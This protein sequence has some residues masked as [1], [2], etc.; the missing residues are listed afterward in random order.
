MA[1]EMVQKHEYDCIVLDIQ[2]PKMNGVEFMHQVNELNLNLT[3]V[4]VSSVAAESGEET[5][6]CL[7][8][9]AFDFVKKPASLSDIKGAS[10]SKSILELIHCA[11]DS[12]KPKAM[13]K[14][15]PTQAEIIKKREIISTRSVKSSA[16]LKG[17]KLIAL[18]CSTG[19]PKALQE[20]IPLLPDNID[21]P[22]VIVQHMPE[23]FTKSLAER[24]DVA[25][26]VKVK[27]AEEGDVLTKG[28]VY[29][30]KGGC[31][32][33]INNKPGGNGTISL[34]KDPPR[35]GLRPCADIM[36]ESLV[37]STYDQ[38]ICVVLTGMGAD[39]TSGI[40]LLK[41]KKKIYVISQD[42]ESCTVYGMPKMI[43]ESGATDEVRPLSDIASAIT[44]ITGVR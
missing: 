15:L 12:A 3:V 1:L 22:M 7:G 32:L 14:K 26:R 24:L 44:S 43:Y 9:G 23:G 36:Y 38:I 16:V 29:I 40:N 20:V 6:Q 25:S 2:M 34:L 21:A 30:A 35:G 19:G 33:I 17:K 27:E 42:K 28:N 39:G 4:L 41:S 13:H 18:A 11:I 31:H 8:Y 37:D 5:I 10:F